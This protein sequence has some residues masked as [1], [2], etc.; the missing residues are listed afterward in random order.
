MLMAKDYLWQHQK[1]ENRTHGVELSHQL[2]ERGDLIL[3]REFK[4]FSLDRHH[5]WLSAGP[6]IFAFLKILG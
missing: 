5:V 6:T 3:L 4:I 2:K 1:S